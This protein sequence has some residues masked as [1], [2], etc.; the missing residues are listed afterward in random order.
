MILRPPVPQSK[1][2][3][4]VAVW[5]TLLT[6][7]FPERNDTFIAVVRGRQM[8]YNG[9]EWARR[10]GPLAGVPSHRAADLVRDLLLDGFVVETSDGIAA[11]ARSGDYPPECKRWIVT[12][13]GEFEGW[14][15][16]WWGKAEPDFYHR[17][18]FITGS[19][20]DHAYHGV[21]VP[22]EMYAEVVDFATM[23]AFQIHPK[24]Q[25]IIDAA[26]K[27][28]E[29]HVILDV[30]PGEPN[31]Q[32][33]WRRP[34]MVPDAAT[35][36]DELADFASPPVFQT[37]TTLFLHQLVA[38]AHV[39]Q[40]KVGALFMDMG[41]G[42]TR[43]AIELAAQRL[44]RI[45][46]IVWFCPVSLKTTTV[47]E[48]LKHT[49]TDPDQIYVF[50]DETTPATVPEV[51]WYI[52]GTESISSSDR[53]TLTANALIDEH[54]MVVVDESSY[55]KGH[56]SKRTRRITQMAA[57]SLYRLIMT[58][59]PLS[60]GVEDLY[61]Q[62]RFLSPQILGY[63]SFYS[64][65]ANHLE[66]HPDYPGMVVRAHNTEYLATKIA[67]YVYQVTKNDAGLNLPEKL[68]EARYCGLTNA[69]LDA[70][71]RAK[72]EVLSEVELNG[73][74][75]LKLFSVLQ[76][77][78]SGFWNNGEVTW[79]YP[80]ERLDTLGDILQEIGETEP[81]IVWCKYIYSL[82][83]IVDLLTKT[84]GTGSVS[85]YYGDLDE[86][87]RDV[88]LARW[89]AGASR[90]F[91]ATM[92]T[93]GHGLT[94][95]RAAYSVFYENEFSYAHRIQ[96]EDR[97]HRIGQAR[98]PTYVDIFAE[99]GIERRIERA[100]SRKEDVVRAFRREV[101]RAKDRREKASLLVEQL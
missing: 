92:S 54:T 70:Y 65:A 39:A 37:T 19:R 7:A 5:D 66:Y 90:F 86:H 97:A 62:M 44:P 30:Q 47:H 64:F 79:E 4:K 80:H 26:Q 61:A 84:Y 52:I 33:E 6:A 11:L 23:H 29:G 1:L 81:V 35:V 2:V 68:N 49:D 93:G 71:E 100:L 63:N 67:P 42:K 27:R 99:C 78:V 74:E 20:Y 76:Q 25:A 48:I 46:R 17:A 72:H 50:D 96:A 95:V 51:T 43:C 14:L 87:Q 55:I 101:G 13:H 83:G 91:V 98:R 28:A 8:H 34:H 15:R 85:L 32:P 69:Q 82:H 56:A 58:G 41:T 3:A 60:Q 53:V 31:A 89:Q 21:V 88:E 59:T 73:Y 94:L 9:N 18:Q 16:F 38:I 12:G 75:L 24:A 10:L 36:V 45:S 57:R 77:I 40:L 22:A